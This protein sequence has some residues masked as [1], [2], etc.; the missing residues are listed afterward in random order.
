MS[1]VRFFAPE[2]RLGKVIAVP[3]GK[4]IETAVA[5]AE[6]QLM[7]VAGESAGKID[8]LLEI[9]YQTTADEAPTPTW[10]QI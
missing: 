9:V 7:L 6:A 8:E 2:N 5:D 1:I 10:S 4:K 3:G